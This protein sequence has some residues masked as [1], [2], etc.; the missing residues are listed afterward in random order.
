VAIWAALEGLTLTAPPHEDPR[1]RAR[2]QRLVDTVNAS[3]PPWSAIARFAILPHDFSV[4][5]GELG[6][7]LRVR[8][9]HCEARYRHVLD[10][11]YEEDPRPPPPRATCP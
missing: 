10:A 6:S 8:R 9:R 4:E 2:I 11:L 7:T 3:L 1:V 5:T